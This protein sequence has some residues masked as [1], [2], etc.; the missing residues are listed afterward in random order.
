[1]GCVCV[2]YRC[3][4]PEIRGVY[5]WGC[6]GHPRQGDGGH[7]Q[8]VR[9]LFGVAR[10]LAV[11]QIAA[12]TVQGGRAGRSSRR[13]G[14]R[15]AGRQRRKSVGRH[16]ELPGP[17][18]HRHRRLQR[19]PIRRSQWKRFVYNNLKISPITIIIITYTYIVY[20]S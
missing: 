20:T 15:R 4:V 10:P 12:D 13:S 17:V 9:V 2:G 5:S 7:R 19:P 14:R 18:R 8:P 6:A 16:A 1:L 11:Q 3:G